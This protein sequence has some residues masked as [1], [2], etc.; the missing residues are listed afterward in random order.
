ML[1][2]SKSAEFWSGLWGGENSSSELDMSDFPPSSGD[3]W[4]CLLP[5]ALLFSLFSLQVTT[6]RTC[7]KRLKTVPAHTGRVVSDQEHSEDLE[8]C[9]N[10]NK[11]SH[12]WFTVTHKYIRPEPIAGR[13][14]FSFHPFMLFYI[15]LLYGWRRLIDSNET[16]FMSDMFGVYPCFT[17]DTYLK[18][19]PKHM[20]SMFSVF[21]PL[22]PPHHF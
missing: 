9:K 16:S 1:P 21:S 6:R 22:S 14:C 19:L 11:G 3:S 18:N 10:N 15:I 8:K 20:A 17:F 2:W 12:D 13:R 4:F 7:E 5:P